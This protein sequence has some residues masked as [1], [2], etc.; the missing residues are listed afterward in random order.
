MQKY[1]I[2]LVVIV[3]L[4]ALTFLIHLPDRICHI[5]PPNGSS[6]NNF[7]Q[8]AERLIRHLIADSSSRATCVRRV[9]ITLGFGLF[10]CAA[11]VC[12]LLMRER[13][14]SRV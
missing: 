3:L 12:G 6:F 7:V 14:R 13:D 11:G 1:R 5:T 10:T 8:R 2:L 9:G 4:A